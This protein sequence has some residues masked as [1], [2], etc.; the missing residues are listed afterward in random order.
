VLFVTLLQLILDIV[1]LDV[2]HLWLLNYKMFI[3]LKIK[4]TYYCKDSSADFIY[5]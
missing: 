3:R 4:H 1:V 5:K 2:I